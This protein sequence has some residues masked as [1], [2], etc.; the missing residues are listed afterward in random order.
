MLSNQTQIIFGVIIFV[1]I[2]I[3]IWTL[4]IK[5]YNRTGI[6]DLRLNILMNIVLPF[7]IILL[8]KLCMPTVYI[9]GENEKIDEFINLIGSSVEMSN[10]QKIIIKPLESTLINNSDRSLI[11]E[12]VTYSFSPIY[13]TNKEAKVIVSPY[14][15]QKT[16][17]IDYFFTT[18]PNS[19]SVKHGNKSEKIWLHY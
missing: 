5:S 13:T 8:F 10:A 6:L 1:I 17:H 11:L 19:I 12:K 14:T 3:V 4:A 16:N 18:P 2:T 7:I 15:K 9:V